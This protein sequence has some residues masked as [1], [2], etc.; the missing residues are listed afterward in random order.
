MMRHLSDGN[1][2]DPTYIKEKPLFIS[3]M[4]SSPYVIRQNLRVPR[5]ISKEAAGRLLFK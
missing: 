1:F 4:G 3:K 5:T 2:S